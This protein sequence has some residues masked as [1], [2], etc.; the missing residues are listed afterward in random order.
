MCFCNRET[1]IEICRY[2]V[3]LRVQERNSLPLYLSVEL[4]IQ[5]QKQPVRL[6]RQRRVPHRLH[7]M[8][9]ELRRAVLSPPN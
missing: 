4:E 9:R 8:S 3:L 2:Q 7:Q 6:F 5:S 1:V